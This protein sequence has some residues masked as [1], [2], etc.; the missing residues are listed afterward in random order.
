MTVERRRELLDD[1]LAA[2]EAEHF[3]HAVN[4]ELL[5]GSSGEAVAEAVTAAWT[6]MAVLD[7][8]HEKVRALRDALAT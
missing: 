7:D 4:V 5:E 1:R 3:Q 2:L 6:A 8:A